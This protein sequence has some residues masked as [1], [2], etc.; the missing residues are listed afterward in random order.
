MKPK[1]LFTKTLLRWLQNWGSEPGTKGE[2]G[3]GPKGEKEVP[4]F[5]DTEMYFPFSRFSVSEIGM[6]LK[7]LY[8]FW[9]VSLPTPPPEKL[10]LN[11]WYILKLRRCGTSEFKKLSKY[12]KACI[13]FEKNA[14]SRLRR[15]EQRRQ[16]LT[17]GKKT[18]LKDTMSACHQLHCCSWS[19]R[20]L[21]G[22][23][24]VPFLAN[25]PAR[26]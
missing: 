4:R 13:N 20:T 14:E 11:R 22:L 12:W 25:N 10:L 2:L 8:G 3:T 6:C 23:E 19:G 5:L 24:L 18:G 1:E 9:A 15:M 16:F 26:A 7:S 17:T 21:A